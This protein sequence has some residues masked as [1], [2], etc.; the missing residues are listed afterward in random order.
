MTDE[1]DLLADPRMQEAVGQIQDL[2]RQRFSDATF[3]V[4]LGEDPVGVYLRATVDVEDRGE[5]VD[6][7]IDRLVDAQVEEE[8]PLIVVVNRPPERTAALIREGVTDASRTP[9]TVASS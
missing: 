6:L 4:G 7:F 8:L 1:S 3:S 5:V 9:A 2:I